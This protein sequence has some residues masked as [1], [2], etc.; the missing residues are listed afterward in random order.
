MENFIKD[1]LFRAGEKI[2]SFFGNTE[3][4]Y[5]KQTVADIVTEADIAS[6]DLIC[7]AIKKNYPDHGIVSEEGEG[8]QTDSDYLWCI[9][10]LDGT[11]N[12]ASQTPLFGI[13]IALV[14]KGDV[15]HAAIYLPYL[16]DYIYAEKGKGAFLNG[17]KA[18]CSQKEDWKGSYGLGT[19][20]LKPSYEKFQQG[21][22]AL[23]EGTGWTNAV[24]SSAVSGIWVS[25]GKRDWYIGPSKNA[26]DYVATSLIAKEA[27]CIVSNF[28]GTDYKPGDHGLVVANKFLFPELI[29]LVKKSYSK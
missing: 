19:V 9:D 11:K 24:A 10:P 25:S 13:N 5:A 7:E 20:M 22:L 12:F 4:L 28:E 17:K 26:W 15:T 3:T 29:E 23:S 14:H 6:N 27:G 16:K 21:I 8:Y 1:T 18:I 2:L